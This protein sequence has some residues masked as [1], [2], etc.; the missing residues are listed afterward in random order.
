MDSAGQQRHG[1]HWHDGRK[2]QP[3][4]VLL[5]EMAGGGERKGI[6]PEPQV[7]H[8]LRPAVERSHEQGGR[9]HQVQP[10]AERQGGGERIA[11]GHQGKA[12]QQRQ[13]C[14]HAGNETQERKLRSRGGP[15]W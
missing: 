7:R 1:N 3:G 15:A 13:Q 5:Q 2:A 14:P 4:G 8:G 9:E 11:A 10:H 12:P 6:K